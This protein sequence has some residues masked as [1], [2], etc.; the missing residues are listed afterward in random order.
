MLNL[1]LVAGVIVCAVQ[2]IRA[3]RLLVSALWLAGVS[4]LVA[5][6]L[7]R[8]GAREVAVIELSVGAGL[9]TVLFVFAISIAGDDAMGAASVIPVPLAVGLMLAF[10][11]LLAWMVLPVDQNVAIA[12]TVSFESA[13][14]GDRGLDVLVQ[15]VLIFAG[16]LCLLGVLQDRTPTT[17]HSPD[18]P[19]IEPPS[20]ENIAV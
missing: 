18:M 4:A 19:E 6:L 5:V 2:A 8:L 13:L 14:W 11:A 1:L 3:A 12:E 20:K 16:V 10:G 15:I 7:Y 9:V 17:H